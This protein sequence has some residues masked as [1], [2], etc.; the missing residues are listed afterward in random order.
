VKLILNNLKPDDNNSFHNPNFFCAVMQVAGAWEDTGK[1]R[2]AT[3]LLKL[4]CFVLIRLI[5]CLIVSGSGIIY[6]F[7]LIQLDAICAYE[8]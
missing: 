2:S 8:I 7:I 1:K 5:E 3:V 4:Y 6:A